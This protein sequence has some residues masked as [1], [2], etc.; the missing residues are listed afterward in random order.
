MRDPNRIPI[1]LE[2]LNKIWSKYPDLRFNQ[3]MV[4]IS[5]EYKTNCN[6]SFNIEDSVL[7]E[8][9]DDIIQKQFQL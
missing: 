5:S 3:L 9:L 4:I 6:D 7:E 1:I 8:R 2:K